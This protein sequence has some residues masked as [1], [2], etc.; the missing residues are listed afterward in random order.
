MPKIQRIILVYQPKIL[1]ENRADLRIDDNHKP[2][3]TIAVTPFDGFCGFRPLKEIVHF[4]EN[5]LSLR[6]LVGDAAAA[7]FKDEV[8]GHETSDSADQV[9]KNKQALQMIFTKLMTSNK[10]SVTNAAKVLIAA[11]EKEGSEFAG[12]GGPSNSGQELADLVI[13]LNTQF[14]GDI[15]LFVLFFLNYVKLE[16][17]EAMFLK[18][19]D[20]HAYLSGGKV[21]TPDCILS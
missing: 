3:M 8:N 15:G 2:E 11:A 18:A 13:R 6:S 20:I 5:V 16:V 17:G 19:D 14:E 12:K 10:T 1:P 4:L 21:N 9:A 7:K